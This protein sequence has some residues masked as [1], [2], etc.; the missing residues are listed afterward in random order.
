V[1][2]GDD[3]ESTSGEN[4]PSMRSANKARW[5]FV[6]LQFGRI[7]DSSF[8]Q[9]TRPTIFPPCRCLPSQLKEGIP[10]TLNR[11]PF[12][13][14]SVTCGRAWATLPSRLAD[15]TGGSGSIRLARQTELDRLVPRLW[16]KWKAAL[17][18]SSAPANNHQQP[19]SQPPQRGAL[20]ANTTRIDHDQVGKSRK[21]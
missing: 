19:R 4:T 14:A 3:Y 10:A 21:E 1:M 8:S 16:F 2:F 5:M 18:S 11:C 17:A 6:L 7:R 12:W 9:E 20:P 13:Q 15:F